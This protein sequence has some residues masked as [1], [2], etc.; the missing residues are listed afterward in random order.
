MTDRFI[1]VPDSLELPAAV[2]V[3]VARLVGPTGAAATPADLAAATAAQGELADTAVQPGDLGNA[4]GLDVGAAAGSVMAGDDSRVTSLPST[5]APRSRAAQPLP[6]TN[7]TVTARATDP[8]PAEF[9]D[10]YI[11][12]VEANG[13]IKR[14]SDGGTTWATYTTIAEIT[15]GA[16]IQRIMPC[17]D[18]EVLVST[19]TVVYRS[20]GWAGGSPTWATVLTNPTASY[21]YPWGFDGD[22]TKFIIVHYGGSNPGAYRAWSRYGWISLDGGLT[23]TVKWDTE[24]IFGAEN[25]AL[26]HLHGACYDPWEDRF[27]INEG[28]EPAMTGV[29]MSTDDGDTWTR[30][31]YG[32]SFHGDTPGNSPTTIVATD[33]GI[34]MG[35]DDPTNGLVVLPRGADQIER[36]WSRMGISNTTLLGYAH[37]GTRDPNTGIVYNVYE[38]NQTYANDIGASVS[39]SD[40]QVAA[41]VA[42]LT[43]PTHYLWRRV[44]VDDDGNLLAWEQSQNQIL[45]AKT[46]GMGAR[47]AHLL[48]TGRVL[49][50]SNIGSRGALAVGAEAVVSGGVI[51][52]AVGHKATASGNSGTAV[53]ASSVSTGNGQ[54][55]GVS[56][57]AGPSGTAVGV[58]AYGLNGTAV[59]SSARAPRTDN[60]AVGNTARAATD[61]DGNVVHATAV[62]PT[63]RASGAGGYTTALG[64]AAVAS[65]DRSTALGAAAQATTVRATAVGQN[66]QATT[67][68]YGVAIGADATCTHQDSVA[69]GRG[70]TT[71]TSLQVQIG[72]RHIAMLEVS[73]P[74]AAPVDGAR[75]Y[76]RDNGAGKTQLCVRF[77]TGATQVI[78]TEP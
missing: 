12:G 70:S 62:G 31:T 36:A 45:R 64:S 42:Q 38:L 1:T 24:A 49:G 59:G 20:T 61:A 25:N 78:A 48:D 30:L 34:V 21:F 18:G 28:H 37:M 32:T 14:S 57:T 13:V 74:A 76:A 71:T 3:P 55:L 15:G 41:Q 50:G 72:G 17:A 35:T 16:L 27:F 44:V 68:L 10:G 26:T 47:P 8:I 33:H 2:K 75:L 46:S 11:W 63:A 40:G 19:P 52:T 53:G 39:G 60:L 43:E 66:A 56:S 65:G 7:V 29:Y 5:Y 54:A 77:A 73:D 69:L 9:F 23:W 58:S 4:A 51:A 67:A 6:L 22:G